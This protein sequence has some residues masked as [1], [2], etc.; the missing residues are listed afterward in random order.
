MIIT[1]TNKVFKNERAF[2]NY[3]KNCC[4]HVGAKKIVDER[5]F[6]T[7]LKSFNAIGSTNAVE[8]AY[9]RYISQGGQIIVVC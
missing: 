6:K 1:S 5:L 7:L 3:S 2:L 4:F 9:M 8:R